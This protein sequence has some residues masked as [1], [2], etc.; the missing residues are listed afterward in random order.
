MKEKGEEP[1]TKKR[2]TTEAEKDDD[3]WTYSILLYLTISLFGF[4]LQD[5]LMT[6]PLEFLLH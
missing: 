1:D 6:S 5:H 2:R 4:Y 3:D